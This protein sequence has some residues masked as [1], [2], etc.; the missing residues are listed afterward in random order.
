MKVNELMPHLIAKDLLTRSEREK[1][2]SL[3]G[4]E[5]DQNKYLL[6]ILPRK[7]D[8]SYKLFLECLEE[9]KEHLGHKDIV[10]WLK[11]PRRT[12]EQVPIHV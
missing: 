6:K 4:L 5:Y 2:D 1:L 3:Q 9:E 7:G 11:Q 10:E 8:H 12:H